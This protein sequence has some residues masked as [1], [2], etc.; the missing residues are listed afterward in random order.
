L[1]GQERKPT[2][3]RHNKGRNKGMDKM[4]ASEY[5]VDAPCAIFAH[6]RGGKM[7]TKGLLLLC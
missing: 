7:E 4:P 3:S 6:F 5:D 1:H 2:M